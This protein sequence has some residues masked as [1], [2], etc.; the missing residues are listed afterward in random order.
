MNA[1]FFFTKYLT[2]LRL[3]GLFSFVLLGVSLGACQ[4]SKQENIT[5]VSPVSFDTIREQTDSSPSFAGQF[6]AARHAQ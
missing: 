1:S 3:G 4:S 5:S 6:L 2:G